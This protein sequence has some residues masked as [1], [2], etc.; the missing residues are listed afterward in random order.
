MTRKER[1]LMS[2]SIDKDTWVF[3]V[4]QKT[5]NIE[6]I[7]GQQ[8]SEHDIFFI[9]AFH[10]RD[11]AMQGIHQITRAPGQT[12]EIQAIIHGD[13]VNYAKK[14]GCLIFFLDGSGRILTK[15]SPDGR[16]L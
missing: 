12:Y 4:V 9:P 15:L 16:T 7:V 6:T 11:T 10:D 13:L 5:G 3:V 8:E 14:I 1:N 2:D